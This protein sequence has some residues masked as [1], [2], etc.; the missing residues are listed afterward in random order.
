MNQ[1]SYYAA[2]LQ[3]KQAKDAGAHKRPPFPGI[4]S[5]YYWMAGYEG[6]DYQSFYDQFNQL[7]TTLSRDKAFI[8]IM[9]GRFSALACA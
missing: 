6:V 8:Q 1:K 5:A 4:D 3:G 9:K 7:R 2:Y